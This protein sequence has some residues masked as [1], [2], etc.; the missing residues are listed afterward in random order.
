M[1]EVS[2]TLCHEQHKPA[3]PG[4]VENSAEGTVQPA[5]VA[6]PA[7]NVEKSAEAAGPAQTKGLVARIEKLAEAVGDGTAR[8]GTW[9]VYGSPRLS[10]CG[11]WCGESDG[12]AR[13]GGP[14]FCVFYSASSCFARITFA[15]FRKI[16]TKTKK[17]LTGRFAH[18]FAVGN[19]VKAKYRG[20]KSKH[21]MEGG[22]TWSPGGAG[23][24]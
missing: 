16:H 3:D 13:V 22:R 6:E 11:K 9:K 15:K 5:E 21:G 2:C 14:V 10:G 12:G 24:S 23:G 4:A 7:R 8:G 19:T 1:F 17:P 18:P 20:K